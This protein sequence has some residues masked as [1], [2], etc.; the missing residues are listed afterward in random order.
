MYFLYKN[1]NTRLSFYAGE[2]LSSGRNTQAQILISTA[3][4]VL[5]GLIFLPIAFVERLPHE[6]ILG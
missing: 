1:I 5:I 2:V 4:I 6:Y 3:S